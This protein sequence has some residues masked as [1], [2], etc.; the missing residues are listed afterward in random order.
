MAP[1]TLFFED[2]RY[3]RTV[4]AEKPERGSAVEAQGAVRLAGCLPGATVLDAGCGVGR[5]SWPLARAG[6]KVVGL[7]SSRVLLGAA[8]SPARGEGWP[9]FVRGSYTALPFGPGSFDAVLC[10][11]TALGYLGEAADRAALREF[12]RVLAPGGRLVIET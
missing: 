4:V 6:Y 9:R 12:R 1:A 8:R 11:G 5:H 3:L 10:L 7:D 2:E